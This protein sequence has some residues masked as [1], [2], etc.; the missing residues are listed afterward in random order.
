[1]EVDDALAEAESALRELDDDGPD[2][3]GGGWPRALLLSP[4]IARQN[5]F[6][7]GAQACAL[8]D[9]ATRPR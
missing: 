1:M 3:D 8:Q 6:S 7:R 4:L 2:H 9:A 5:S